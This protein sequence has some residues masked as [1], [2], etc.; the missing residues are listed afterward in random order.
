MA[1]FNT[2][3]AGSLIFWKIGLCVLA[4]LEK[5]CFLERLTPPTIKK[6]HFGPPSLTT[7]GCFSFFTKK[8][9]FWRFL[10]CFS[11]TNHNDR[12]FNLYREKTPKNTFFRQKRK[13]P[14]TVEEGGQKWCFLIVGGVRRPKSTFFSDEL[15]HKPVFQKM[16]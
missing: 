15:A 7:K 5:R 4:H 11:C 8:C 9:V 2:P 6:H 14:M 12:P 1:N 16:T 10:T 3:H 13:T